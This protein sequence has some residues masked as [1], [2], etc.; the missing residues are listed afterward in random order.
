[1]IWVLCIGGGLLVLFVVTKHVQW[2]E[3]V[4]PIAYVA[5]ARTIEQAADLE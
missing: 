1:M 5:F 2:G 3:A 4:D